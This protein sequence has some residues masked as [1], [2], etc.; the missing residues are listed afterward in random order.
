M[1]LLGSILN[2]MDKPPTVS[3]KQKQLLKR[4]ENILFL[5]FCNLF[6]FMVLLFFPRSKARIIE[7]TEC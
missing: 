7:K 2:S 5:K 1:D 4:K 6:I 3:D